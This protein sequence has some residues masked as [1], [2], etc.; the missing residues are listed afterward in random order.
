MKLY[1]ANA[2]KHIQEFIYRIP[3]ATQVVRQ[4]IP[5]G[6]QILVYQDAPQDVLEYI[7][8]MHADTP[9]PW[10]VSVA[11]ARKL[12]SFAGLVYSFDKPVPGVT[13]EERFAL[14]NEALE[15]L[16]EE[17]RKI[18]AVAASAKAEE[19]AMSTGVE[20]N[21]VEQSIK[22]ESRIGESDDAPK[23]DQRVEVTRQGKRSKR[24][25]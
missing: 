18:A 3:E 17:Q 4:T 15:A 6:G 16:G 24:N 8:K 21:T 7:L 10:C 9:L 22:E 2:T 5:M 20:V 12:H 1:I 14:N 19:I 11:E 25:G 23:L 13:I